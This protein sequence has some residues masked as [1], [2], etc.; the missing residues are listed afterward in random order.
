M[1]LLLLLRSNFNNLSR[2]NGKKLQEF[3]TRREEF[4]PRI[5]RISRISR[6]RIRVCG[7]ARLV[8]DNQAVL[9][10][11]KAKALQAFTYSLP[12]ALIPNPSPL[13]T[14]Y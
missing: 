3:L 6:E 4:W 1:I 2:Q 13:I 14:N 10:V 8:N 12:Y 11:N 5:S 9:K 7:F